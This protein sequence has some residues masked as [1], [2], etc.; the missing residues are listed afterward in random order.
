M[1]KHFWICCLAF[2]AL[3]LGLSACQ[4][5]HRHTLVKTE[6][7]EAVCGVGGNLAYFTCSECGEVF[8]DEDAVVKTTVEACQTEAL[9]HTWREAS[10]DAAKTCL[11]CG[12]TEGEALS[13]LWGEP[14]YVLS[15]DRKSCTASRLCERDAS[16][17]DRE[18]ATVTAD[19]FVYTVAFENEAFKDF[20]KDLTPSITSVEFA[21]T[22]SAQYDPVTKTFTVDAGGGDMP[23][24]KIPGENLEI[25][26]GSDARWRWYISYEERYAID[27]AV[28]KLVKEDGCYLFD[29]KDYARSSF[30]TEPYE[31]AFTNDGKT[32]IKTGYFIRLEVDENARVEG[33]YFNSDSAAYDAKTNTFT[34]SDETPLIITFTGENPVEAITAAALAGN[35]T[36]ALYVF[37][38]RNAAQGF[39]VSDEGNIVWTVTPALLRDMMA[40]TPTINVFGY[41][42]DGVS[43]TEYI[44]I[45][46]ILDK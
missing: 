17:I 31:L 42:A 13:H 5:E 22:D 41:T 2:M 8:S 37:D 24:L 15:A 29:M 34:V 12:K 14:D 23:I 38:M 44:E 20:T 30:S 40:H 43:V 18:V 1:K 28:Q 46:I 9:S 45:N 25:A 35:K 11:A 6:A 10:C 32:L 21:N 39:H 16:H 26:Y 36:D 27:L 3:L 19:G 7:V 33:M 4:E